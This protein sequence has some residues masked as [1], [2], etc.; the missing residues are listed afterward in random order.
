MR[1]KDQDTLLK[2]VTENYDLLSLAISIST[3]GY[4]TSEPLIA[5]R[6]EGQYI[7]VEGNRRLATLLLLADPARATAIGTAE[8]R[9]IA[10]LGKEIHA[11]IRSG[12]YSLSFVP[13]SQ[14]W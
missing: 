5:L 4:F 13:A 2:Y 8:G 7:V 14:R 11:R 9:R 12:I 6:E 10:E 3:Y 1:G